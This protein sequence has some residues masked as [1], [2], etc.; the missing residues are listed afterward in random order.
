M[1]TD[2]FDK[3]YMLRQHH[4]EYRGHIA[5]TGVAGA[6]A[7][8][9]SGEGDRERWLLL[10]DGIAGRRAMSL[11]RNVSQITLAL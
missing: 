5:A 1:V 8:L 9:A 4:D 7:R 3:S 6:T 11:R 10:E 2:C